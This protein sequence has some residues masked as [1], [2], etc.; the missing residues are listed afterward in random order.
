MRLLLFRVY[1]F[2]SCLENIFEKKEIFIISL[3]V[4]TIKYIRI[5]ILYST[6]NID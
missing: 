5:Y 1:T 2:I 6:H 3:T 4:V